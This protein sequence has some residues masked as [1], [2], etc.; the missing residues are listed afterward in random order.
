VKYLSNFGFSFHKLILH[1]SYSP[2]KLITG[3]L[4]PNI[5][6]LRYRIASSILVIWFFGKINL[7]FFV[8]CCRIALSCLEMMPGGRR[9]VSK[10]KTK[11]VPAVRYSP[12]DHTTT[13]RPRPLSSPTEPR[14][15]MSR[16]TG[17]DWIA[18]TLNPSGVNPHPP[19][20]SAVPS[21][22]PVPVQTST[23]A[24]SRTF[25]TILS[26]LG[27]HDEKSHGVSNIPRGLDET[28]TVGAD[29][30]QSYQQA[31][32]GHHQTSCGHYSRKRTCWRG[33]WQPLTPCWN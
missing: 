4:F 16:T 7:F 25:P 20:S 32:E 12:A 26:Q 21:R 15:P 1:K 8:F 13:R 22:I 23:P 28:V 33:S 9:R 29:F 14:Q 5:W 3:S 31:I 10:R 11:G 30:G 2:S 19:P 17:S 24:M 27:G 6:S 18:S